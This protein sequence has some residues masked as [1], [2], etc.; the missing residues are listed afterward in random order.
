MSIVEEE[1]IYSEETSKII[2]AC[3]EVHNTLGNGFVESVYQEAL[4]IELFKRDI[5]Y[6][7]EQKLEIWYKEDMLTKFFIADFVCYD[8]IIIE[9]KT[10]DEITND[11]IGQVINYLKATNFKLGLLINFGTPKLQIKRLIR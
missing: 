4:M 6:C 3:F 2:S 10:A 5:P 9:L 11:H 7:S 8:K 1:Y